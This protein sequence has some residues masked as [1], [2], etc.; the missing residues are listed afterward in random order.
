MSYR[1]A[2]LDRDH[3][4]PLSLVALDGL[5][6]RLDGLPS[7]GDVYAGPFLEG[8]ISGGHSFFKVLFCCDRHRPEFLL[9]EGIDAGVVLLGISQ[10]AINNLEVSVSSGYLGKGRSVNILELVKRDFG[11]HDGWEQ[12]VTA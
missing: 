6:E 12:E 5:S 9:G 10:L 7:L 8:G 3:L 1:L 2:S 11:R 4:H